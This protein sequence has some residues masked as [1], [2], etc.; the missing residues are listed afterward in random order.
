MMYINVSARDLLDVQIQGL[1]KEIASTYFDDDIEE[2]VAY[3]EL[4]GECV[5]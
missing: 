3:I 2:A 4:M 5:E 1:I